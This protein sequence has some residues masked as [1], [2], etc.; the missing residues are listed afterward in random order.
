MA[1]SRGG[2]QRL[3][4]SLLRVKRA[5]PTGPAA[6]S[7]QISRTDLQENGGLMHRLA[8]RKLTLMGLGA[9]AAVLVLSTLA[10]SAQALEEKY[11]PAIATVDG[12]P[13]VLDLGNV[14]R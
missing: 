10:R 2:C 12:M 1:L 13:A 11:T 6:W 5:S 7:R 14:Y 8:N 9:V 4:G 3:A